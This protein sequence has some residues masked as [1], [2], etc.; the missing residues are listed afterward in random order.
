[1]GGHFALRRHVY[2][3]EV[4]VY[5]WMGWMAV[6]YAACWGLGWLWMTYN[7]L[8]DLRQ[9][10]KRAWTLVDIEL[11]RR[12]ELIPGLVQVLEALREHE[13]GVLELL[14]RLRAQTEAT[15]P[16]EPGPDPLG[17]ATA[18][19]SV[20]EAYPQ[21]TAHTGFESLQS[22]LVN[23]EQRIALA[24]GYFN[25]I[26]RFFNTRIQTFPGLWIARLGG[27]TEHPLLSAHEFER[28]Q[29]ELLFEDA[30]GPVPGV[31]E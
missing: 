23:T 1:L 12:A 21:L 22:R 10:V 24:R 16:G 26:C 15:E 4:G 5:P 7:S 6:G 2:P 8:V 30:Q 31:A 18:L 3:E 20:V 27:M 29:V 9:R 17:C 25:E 14:A 13:R 11:K 19:R 28:A